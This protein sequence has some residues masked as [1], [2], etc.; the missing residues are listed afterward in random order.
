MPRLRS[1]LDVQLGLGHPV[2]PLRGAARMSTFTA[3]YHSHI[4]PDDT[5]QWLDDEVVH[6]LC[7]DPD[8]PTPAPA[9][10]CTECWMSKPCWCDPP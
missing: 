4:S 6:V 8:R 3:R 9:E 1:P 7:A 2:R 10:I 5:V